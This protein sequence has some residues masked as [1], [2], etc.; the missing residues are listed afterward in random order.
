MYERVTSHPLIYIKWS[1]L[2]LTCFQHKLQIRQTFWHLAYYPWYV[3]HCRTCSTLATIRHRSPGSENL[4]SGVS[5]Q[6]SRY[7]T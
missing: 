1:K 7:H 4:S 2:H 3:Q 6:F 5:T